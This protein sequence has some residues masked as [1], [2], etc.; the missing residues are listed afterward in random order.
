MTTT[1]PGADGAEQASD[2]RALL[3]AAKRFLA[4]VNEAPGITLDFDTAAESTEFDRARSALQKAIAGVPAQPSQQGD[5]SEVPYMIVFEDRDRANELVI[6]DWRAAE[7]F[8]RISDS[9][10]AHL[11]VKI[12]G[13][14]RDDKMPNYAPAAPLS[15]PV[16]APVE[17]LLDALRS[18][19]ERTAVWPV[20]MAKHALDAYAAALP[21]PQPDNQPDSQPDMPNATMTI[22]SE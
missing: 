2:E 17:G 1:N 20:A 5:N 11:F 22:R 3:S 9:W 14:S 6:G 10:N 4:A 15:Q 13:N 8:K 12:A 7:R 18:I 21:A 19:A 16:A